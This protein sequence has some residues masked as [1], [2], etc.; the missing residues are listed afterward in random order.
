VHFAFGLLT[1][2]D[3]DDLV[4]SELACELLDR[5]FLDLRSSV[6]DELRCR[7]LFGPSHSSFD[8]IRS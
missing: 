5:E 2:I 1:N 3:H 7:C 8:G 6:C 4:A